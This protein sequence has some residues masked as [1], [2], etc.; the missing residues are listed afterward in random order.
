MQVFSYSF[1]S[2]N[3][4]SVGFT[5]DVRQHSQIYSYVTVVMEVPRNP[6]IPE[7]EIVFLIPGRSGD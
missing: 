6:H 7:E 5:N 1:L 4:H 2:S 3:Q